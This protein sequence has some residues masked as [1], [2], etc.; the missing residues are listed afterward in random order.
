[1]ASRESPNQTDLLAVLSNLGVVFSVGWYCVNR[2]SKHWQENWEKHL[3]ILEDPIQGPLYKVVMKRRKPRSLKESAQEILTGSGAFSVSKINQLISIY[4]LLLW[5]A[6][7]I[8]ALPPIDLQAPIDWLYGAVIVAT[9][10]VCISFW[11]LGRTYEGGY[12]HQASIRTT[13]IKNDA[14]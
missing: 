5:V 11:K 1:M 14:E 4:V 10:V 3:D 9:I 2:G 12:W 13:T 7:V 6:L 8:W